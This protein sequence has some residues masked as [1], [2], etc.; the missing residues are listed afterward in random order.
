MDVNATDAISDAA[1][2]IMSDPQTSNVGFYI[3]TR[4]SDPGTWDLPINADWSAADSLAANIA[5]ISL[6][7][8][9]VTLSTPPNAG[10]SWA[11]PYQSQSALLRFT[12]TLT[13]N[14][15]ITVPRAGFFIIENKCTVGSFYVQLVGIGGGNTIGAPPGEKCHVFYDGSNMDYV[16][17]GRVG[18]YID[19]PV[20]AIP[21][22]MTA[23]TA[24]PYLICD[25]SVYNVSTYPA[26]GSMLGST[27]GGNG[28]T[29]FGVPD[30]RGRVNVML[31]STGSRITSACGINGNSLGAAGGDQLLQSHGHTGSTGTESAQ[32]NHNVGV[33][34]L[35]SGG[36]GGL[37]AEV[38]PGGNTFTGT[39]NQNHTHPFTTDPSGS[40]ASQN[41][42]PSIIA[43]IRF[44]K[45]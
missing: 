26:L 19:L 40:G 36:G 10:S 16:D 28:I 5:T 38:V 45:T 12:G 44:I 17:L 7:N 27:F 22:W 42:Q 21:S 41:V 37:G 33:Q 25:G 23:C 30:C 13:G 2:D 20:T 9:P 34:G 3:P 31:D 35:G 24:S 43:G 4:G 39:E 8:A 1:E 6:T 11:G 14:C 18:T 29:T 32:H 15:V